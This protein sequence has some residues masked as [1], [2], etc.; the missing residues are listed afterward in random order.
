MGLNFFN[1]GGKSLRGFDLKMRLFEKD[2]RCILADLQRGAH[3]E[4]KDAILVFPGA[5][6]ELDIAAKGVEL[7]GAGREE[8]DHEIGMIEG[9]ADFFGPVVA[10]FDLF[11]G[12]ENL[13]IAQREA[14]G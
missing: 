11:I 3:I 6:G 5:D 7:H 9:I 2:P 8:D 12:V 10:G 1:G 13:E 4:C 14:F